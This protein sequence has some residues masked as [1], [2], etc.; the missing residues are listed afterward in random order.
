MESTF[1]LNGNGKGR[2][3]RRLN[4]TS[5][6]AEKCFI[7]NAFLW[8]SEV[9]QLC[10]SDIIFRIIPKF[11][12]YMRVSLP[13][14]GK[15]KER[16]D[17]LCFKKKKKNQ[18]KKPKKPCLLGVA[19]SLGTAFIYFYFWEQLEGMQSEYLRRYYSTSDYSQQPDH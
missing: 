14:F 4:W 9:L 17:Y 19:L 8:S 15:Q 11:T 13:Y 3:S 18:K 1:H 10:P 16:C 5:V 7:I 6:T 12:I 2:Y